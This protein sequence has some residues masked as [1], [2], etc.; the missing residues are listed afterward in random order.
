[1]MEEEIKRELSQVLNRYSLDAASNTPDFILAEMVYK[2]I[3]AYTDATK[4]NREWNK[5]AIK[6]P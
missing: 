6:Q 3:S 1:M 2:F 4:E 5:A